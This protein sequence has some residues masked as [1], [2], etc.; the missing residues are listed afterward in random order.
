MQQKTEQPNLT[1]KNWRPERQEAER[2]VKELDIP[3]WPPWLLENPRA[4]VTRAENFPDG[5]LLLVAEN[6][7]LAAYLTSAR[8]EWDG[9][10]ESL[11]TWDTVVGMPETTSCADT[12]RPDG[13]T[14]FLLAISVDHD[15]R[16]Q[17]LTSRLIQEIKGRAIGLSIE[18]AISPFRPSGYG[19]WKQKQ[20][21]FGNETFAEYC[22]MRREDGQPVD[23][24]LRSLK[25]NRMELIRDEND[26][27]VVRQNSM[28]VRVPLDTF[29]EYQ[30]NYNPELWRQA[31]SGEI[32]ECN[33]AGTWH[34]GEKEAVYREPNVL[35]R[36]L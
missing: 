27:I 34:V 33:E 5:Q 30:Q 8:I 6:G 7:Q 25:W 23:P 19:Q 14:I 29:R 17:R 10:P 31:P 1:I 12:H 4:Y 24:W 28:V 2:I 32:W 35:G 15:F 13:N 26:Q 21:L 22:E 3:S 18:H 20:G 9:K 36:I 16:G 11:P